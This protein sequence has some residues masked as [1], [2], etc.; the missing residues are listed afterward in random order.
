MNP[1]LDGLIPDQAGDADALESSKAWVCDKCEN[2]YTGDTC[3]HCEA[4]SAV[5]A[6]WR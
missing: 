1:L 3:P 5:A 6:E 4:V 2:T